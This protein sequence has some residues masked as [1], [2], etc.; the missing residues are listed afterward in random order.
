MELISAENAHKKADAQW[1]P[2]INVINS[3]II[4]AAN[5]GEYEVKIP[6]KIL[7]LTQEK[8][9]DHS[10]YKHVKLILIKVG[11]DVFFDYYYIHIMW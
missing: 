1:E 3:G 8:V 10:F 9:E 4:E 5:K 6:Y 7:G 2:A 11:Y